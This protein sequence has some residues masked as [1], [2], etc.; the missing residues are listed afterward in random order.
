MRRKEAM[1]QTVGRETNQLAIQLRRSNE[2]L[3]LWEKYYQ[4]ERL[5][6]R[7]LEV[8]LPVGEQCNIRCVFCTDRDPKQSP[9]RYAVIGL[10]EF[11]KFFGK[12]PLRTASDVTLYGWGEPLVHRD[13]ERMFDYVAATCPGVRI[14]ISTNGLLFTEKWARKLLD[15]GKAHVNFSLN[16]ATPK[17]YLE[18]TGA[19][20]FEKVVDHIA[21]LSRLRQ[22]FPGTQVT[23]ALS[24]VAMRSVLP[25]IPSFV[26]LAAA[27]GVDHVVVQD[28][29]LLN[30]H[31][32]EEDTPQSNYYLA[33]EV[34]QYADRLSRLNG[35]SLLVEV[36]GL[37]RLVLPGVWAWPTASAVERQPLDWSHLVGDECFDPWTQFMVSSDG[38]VSTCCHAHSTIMGNIFRQSFDEIWNGEIYRYFRRTVNTDR[39][40][41]DC[42]KCPI[43]CR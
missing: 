38:S 39:P 19:D 34:L 37:Y 2:R 41:L 23:I 3:N 8:S 40:P 14:K 4:K 18:I 22:Q 31:L 28:L 32:R 24:L 11:L 20:Q 13:Y 26:M 12:L 33:T 42:R 43:K 10:D 36:T 9:I 29:L 21:T 15:H 27:L 7:P 6:S 5:K 17:T 30:G 16:A 1:L 25:E 35:I